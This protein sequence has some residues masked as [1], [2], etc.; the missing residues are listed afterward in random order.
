MEGP[1]YSASKVPHKEPLLSAD[2]SWSPQVEGTPPVVS[3]GRGEVGGG[4]QRSSGQLELCESD[5]SDK[6]MEFGV[7]CPENVSVEFRDQRV[8]RSRSD[9]ECAPR[10]PSLACGKKQSKAAPMAY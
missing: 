4:S 5:A 7:F 3:R 2:D 10:P 1:V 8:G 9:T 6:S